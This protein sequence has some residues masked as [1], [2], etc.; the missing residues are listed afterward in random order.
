ML[1]TPISRASR[2]ALLTI[3]I[4][5]AGVLGAHHAQAQPCT[6]VTVYNFSN[7]DLNFCLQTSSGKI[8][9]FIPITW[10]PAPGTVVSIPAGATVTGVFDYLNGVHP[11]APNCTSLFQISATCC[12]DVCYDPVNCIITITRGPANC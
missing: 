12:A 6:A 5:V 9:T 1:N 3:A 8:C 4:V 10:P 7:C 11:F 2:A